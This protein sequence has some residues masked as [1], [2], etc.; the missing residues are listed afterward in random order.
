M[1]ISR[2]RIDEAIEGGSNY[3]RKQLLSGNYGLTCIG[4]NGL[5]K[6]SNNKGHLFSVFHMTNALLGK[7]DEIERTIILTRI[8]SEEYNGQWG[9]SPRGYYKDKEEN[10]FFVDSDDT[11]FALRTLKLLDIYRSNEVLLKYKYNCEYNGNHFSAFSTF[12]SDISQKQLVTDPTFEH[13]LHIHPEVN[14]NIYHI[15]LESN[16]DHFI[17]EDLIRLSQKET[18]SWYSYFYPNDYYATFQFLSILNQT[19]QLKSCYNKGIM[20]LK[21][22]QNSNG[23]WGNS[24]PYLSAMALKALCLQEQKTEIIEK[25]ISFLLDS[26][27]ENGAWN[28]K[29]IIWEFHDQEKDTW[30]AFDTHHVITT[31]ACVEVLKAF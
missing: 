13:N 11:T 18:G 2:D 16:Q 23:S 29:E 27:S 10:P 12:I 4:K 15:L 28:S 25:G 24:D 26:L 21:T 14:A 3:L 6:F 31:S 1:E 22:S 17:N 7:L 19:S 5:P 9:Y 30:K 20:F 8:L